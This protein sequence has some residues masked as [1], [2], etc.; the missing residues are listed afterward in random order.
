[1]TS[2]GV[3]MNG[4]TKAMK[5]ISECKT[6]CDG[7]LTDCKSDCDKTLMNCKK[8]CKKPLPECN[9]SCDSDYDGDYE[10]DNNKIELL[11]NHSLVKHRPNSGFARMNGKGGYKKGI[12]Y[13]IK[14][15]LAR[16]FQRKTDRYVRLPKSLHTKIV[17]YRQ[18][19]IPLDAEAQLYKF[20]VLILILWS[21]SS[22]IGS[23]IYFGTYAL[24]VIEEGKSKN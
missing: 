15:F 12:F 21:I 2:V 5:S 1:M 7:Y 6:D 22:L 14:K 16:P 3:P 10:N 24:T 13:S 8:N 19:L 11:G 18:G 17:F 4:E 23:L 20:W 9:S